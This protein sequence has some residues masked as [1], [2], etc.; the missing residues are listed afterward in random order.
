MNTGGILTKIEAARMV[1]TY[2]IPMILSNGGIE[3][4]LQK[5][6]EGKQ[7]ATL[8]LPKED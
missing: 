8:F 5:L 2:G 6:F 1:N 4:V 3:D 7:E